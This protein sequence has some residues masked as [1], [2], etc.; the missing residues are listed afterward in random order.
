LFIT[1]SLVSVQFVAT[2]VWCIVHHPGKSGQCCG[3]SRIIFHTVPA[4]WAN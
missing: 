3:R 2:V 4:L 1:L